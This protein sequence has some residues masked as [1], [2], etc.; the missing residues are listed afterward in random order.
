ME[1]V[2]RVAVLRAGRV[3]HVDTPDRLYAAPASAFVY[4]FLYGPIR[5]TGHSAK[6]MA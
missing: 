3:E 6:T 2:D 1:M 5:G 4:E